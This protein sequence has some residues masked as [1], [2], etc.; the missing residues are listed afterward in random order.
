MSFYSSK[1]ALLAGVLVLAPVLAIGTTMGPAGALCSISWWDGTINE[2][3]IGFEDGN[4][5]GSTCD[6]DDYYRGKVRETPGSDNDGVCAVIRFKPF[7]GSWS[8]QGYS[9]NQD[10]RS[11]RLWHGAG[12]VQICDGWNSNS[13]SYSY[14]LLGA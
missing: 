4:S 2:W 6:E 5:Q 9:C 12:E 13:C 7:D 14:D 3:Y 10:F 1:R 11:Y 8:W